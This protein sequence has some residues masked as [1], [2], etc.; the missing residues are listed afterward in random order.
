MGLYINVIEKDIKR[1]LKKPEIT[2]IKQYFLNKIVYNNALT[3]K[4]KK[5][6]TNVLIRTIRTLKFSEDDIFD[7]KS[8]FKEYIK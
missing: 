4:T 6:Y 8:Y 1:L 2:I 7:L 3:E 5:E